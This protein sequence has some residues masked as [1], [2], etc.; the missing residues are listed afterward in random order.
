MATVGGNLFAPTPY[1]DFTVAL[2]ALDATGGDQAARTIDLDAFLAGAGGRRP[3]SPASTST[4]PRTEALPLRQGRRGSSPRAFRCCPSRAVHRDGCDGTVD[5]G[6]HRA[7]VHGRSSDPRPPA[8][9]AL[10][11][12]SLTEH[13]VASSGGGRHRRHPPATDPIASAWYRRE[14][15]PVHFRR[16]LLSLKAGPGSPIRRGEEGW[17]RRF[18]SNSP[19]TATEKAEFIESGA[20]LLNALRDKLGDTSPKAAAI[21]ARA[22]PARS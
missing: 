14:I 22:A 3:S 10:I 2:L 5:V 4:F 15:L 6:A 18:R 7:R 1:G 8:E 9:E 21:R 13:G 11:G 19:S 20:T 17:R 16:L 12:A